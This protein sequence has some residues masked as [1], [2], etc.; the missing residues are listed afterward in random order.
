M[1]RREHG[2][3]DSKAARDR[4]A[5][6]TREYIFYGFLPAWSE[7]EYASEFLARAHDLVSYRDYREGVDL[8][9]T[10][11]QGR[12][13]EPDERRRRREAAL[14]KQAKKEGATYE[15]IVG[16]EIYLTKDMPLPA[17]AV[18]RRREYAFD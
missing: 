5:F 17:R 11:W 18:T 8:S 3:F 4:L 7:C 9:S 10:L 13:V 14:M 16:W 2:G 15:V 6:Y 1:D 12:R